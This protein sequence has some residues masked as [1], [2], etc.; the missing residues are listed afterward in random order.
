[1]S[2]LQSA[3]KLEACGLLAVDGE[4]GCVKEFYFDEVTWRVC[5]LVVNTDAWLS[6]RPV[7]ISPVAV[8]EVREDERLILIELTR[9]Q[10][11]SSSPIDTHKPVAQQ[12]AIQNQNLCNWPVCEAMVSL[13]GFPVSLDPLVCLGDSQRT[14]HSK[15]SNRYL[16]STAQVKGCAIAAVNGELGYVKEFIIDTQYWVIRYLEVE[17]N[18]SCSPVR[19]V[20]VNPGWIRQVSWGKRILSVNLTHESIK[21]AP[22]LDFSQVISRDYETQLFRH[23]GRQVY[24]Q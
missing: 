8:G 13:C 21:D 20:L 3:Q 12:S 5:Y 23:Y 10:I 11:R 4:I 15:F 6:G 9:E 17:V 7:L 19:H 2:L 22:E 24:W 18:Y 1:M 16:R 14:L